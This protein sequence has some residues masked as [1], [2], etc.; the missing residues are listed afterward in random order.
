MRFEM[1]NED[2][3]KDN[4][5]GFSMSMREVVELLNEYEEIIKSHNKNW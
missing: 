2:T 1:V 4:E 5:Y 3:V